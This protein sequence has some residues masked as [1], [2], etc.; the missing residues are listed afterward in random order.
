M[1]VFISC[2]GRRSQAVGAALRDTMK[3]A[4]Q[5]TDPWLADAD[6]RVGG[7]WNPELAAALE[8][9]D[10]GVSC[11]TPENKDRPWILFEAGAISKKVLEGR[12]AIYLIDLA[13]T[14]LAGPL[15]QFQSVGCD[16]DGTARLFAAV[17]KASASP[18]DSSI[19]N[20]VFGREWTTLE[21]AI[22]VAKAIEHN[23]P[24]ARSTEEILAELV[25]GNRVTDQMLT[26][27]LMMTNS[28][29]AGIGVPP[30]AGIPNIVG[31]RVP[32]GIKVIAD[33]SWRPP[34]D[35]RGAPAGA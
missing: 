5:A 9:S 6:L 16:R 24:K 22:A 33:E 28:I 27:L 35:R 21:A 34:H 23:K 29:R 17:N 19:L 12:L 32:G 7:R 25:A 14:D 18:L 30:T 8:A 26:A 31:E 11:I 10:F 2:S 3:A 1:K 4:I 20:R 13:A 15:A